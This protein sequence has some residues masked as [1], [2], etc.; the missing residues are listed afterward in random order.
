M[1]SPLP[2]DHLGS[3]LTERVRDR[4]TEL[5]PVLVQVRRDLHSHPELS[6]QETRTTDVVCDEEAIAATV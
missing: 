4:V 2:T 3:E 1:N 5:D 6:W